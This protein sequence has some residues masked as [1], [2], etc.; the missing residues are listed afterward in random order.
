MSPGGE[1]P[2]DAVTSFLEAWQA[3]DLDRYTECMT[4]DS[5]I[6]A[7]M[8]EAAREKL[9]NAGAEFEGIEVRT[10]VDEEDPDLATVELVSGQITLKTRKPAGV[11]T[12]TFGVA[13]MAE[14]E[15]P[16]F[17]LRRTSGRWFLLPPEG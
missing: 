14:G 10:V 13:E 6:P 4:P 12:E 5:A 2:R 7:R 9:E 17:Y 15:R 3:A 11:E 16:L 1:T 8:R